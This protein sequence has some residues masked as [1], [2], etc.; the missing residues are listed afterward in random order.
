MSREEFR[1][2]IFNVVEYLTKYELSD[3]AKKLILHYFNT[4]QAD[5][6]RFKAIDAVE[7]YTADKLPE[8]DDMPRKLERLLDKMVHE[9]DRWDAK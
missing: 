1:Q 2:T 6:S 8:L 5:T 3:T 9:A 7:R 4:S